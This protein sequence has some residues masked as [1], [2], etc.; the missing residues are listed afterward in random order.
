MCG[1]IL[2]LMFLQILDSTGYRFD[3]HC[4]WVHGEGARVFSQNKK[5]NTISPHYS[6]INA[7]LQQRQVYQLFM[8]EST[9]TRLDTLQSL[10]SCF[11]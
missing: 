9:D 5:Q 6:L 11:H 8:A 1:K 7:E 10:P 4:V 3:S 2:S